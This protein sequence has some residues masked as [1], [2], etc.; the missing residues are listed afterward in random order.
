MIDAQPRDLRKALAAPDNPE[1]ALGVALGDVARL[2][3]IDLMAS[4]QIAAALGI[5]HHHIRSA[6]DELTSLACSFDGHA[7]LVDQA[8]RATG[9]GDADAISVSGK[10]LRRHI[11]NARRRFGLPVHEEQL[12][13]TVRQAPA[14]AVHKVGRHASAGDRHEAQIRQHLGADPGALHK[15][16]RIGHASDVRAA[17]LPHFIKEARMGG[18][19]RCDMDAGTNRQMRVQ[20]GKPIGIVE[21]QDQCGAVALLQR[22]ERR[23]RACI[24]LE[25]LSRKPDEPTLA[26]RAGRPE[27]QGKVRMDG[28]A[29]QSA[30]LGT[31]PAPIATRNDDVWR[32]IGRELVQRGAIV[33]RQQ[34]NG[35]AAAQGCQIG[36]DCVLRRAGFDSYKLAPGAKRSAEIGGSPV[37]FG[38]ADHL[39]ARKKQRRR[40][41][42]RPELVDEC[43]RPLTSSFGFRT[44]TKKVRYYS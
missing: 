17:C 37:E 10:A 3:L 42:T 39:P 31:P 24:G 5:A 40:V 35:V 15:F 26:C 20:D 21:R 38:V 28:A 19:M 32:E 44:P 13:A 8:E 7:A 22:Q 11:G 1:K 36:D 16:V 41:A 12:L 14:P 43:H 18:A 27:Q 30:C 29:Q 25:R 6:I 2:Q 23:N 9:N 34:R 33:R 4:C